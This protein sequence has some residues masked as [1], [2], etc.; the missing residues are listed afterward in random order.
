MKLLIVGISP[1]LRSEA[2]GH[3]YT[4]HKSLYRALGSGVGNEIAYIG[5]KDSKISDESSWFHRLLPKSMTRNAPWANPFRLIR[6]IKNF[7]ETD[8]TAFIYEGNIAWL[9]LST[10]LINSGSV[11]GAHVNLFNSGTYMKV[12]KSGF[13]TA[14]IKT[15]SRMIM[16]LA[17]DRI[18]ITAETQRLANLIS[19]LIGMKVEAFPYFS[20]SPDSQ[21][22]ARPSSKGQHKKVLINIRGNKQIDLVLEAVRERCMN[23]EFTLHGIA[24]TTFAETIH[25]HNISISQHL[26]SQENY[27]EYFS[28]FD[29][30][31]FAYDKSNFE[32]QS[33]GRLLDAIKCKI[34]VVVPQN[35]SMEDAVN[36]FQ[37]GTAL[38]LDS[39]EKLAIILREFHSLELHSSS[40]SLSDF[41]FLEKY[42]S[43]IKPRSHDRIENQRR[44]IIGFTL[45]MFYSV[46]HL[47]LNAPRFLRSLINSIR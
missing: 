19:E 45:W 10:M 47:P 11:S 18:I 5:A 26:I 9:L 36:Y 22:S 1:F 44:F 21:V 14:W 38:E 6:E 7:P 20:S 17:E 13:R 30:M 28:Q 29:A 4:Y 24:G 43:L 25:G 16:K 34:P 42:L 41:E 46:A 40:A 2:K 12:S 23:C 31:I 33:S 35:T 8:R 15:I 3:H 39:S 37:A 32:M 27:S